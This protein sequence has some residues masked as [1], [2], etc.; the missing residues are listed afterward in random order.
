MKKYSQ[1]EK[2]FNFGISS[3][4]AIKNIKALKLKDDSQIFLKLII[5]NEDKP[6][7]YINFI[8]IPKKYQLEEDENNTE[9][10]IDK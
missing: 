3:K 6:T 9:N 1:Q 7:N 4:I 10:N 5:K 8:N 2:L